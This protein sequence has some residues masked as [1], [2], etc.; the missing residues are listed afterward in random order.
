MSPTVFDVMTRG[1]PFPTPRPT[2]RQLPSDDGEPMDTPWHRLNMHLLIDQIN[3]RWRHRDDF[4][5]GGNMFV[6]FGD[7]E[8]FHKDFRGP[9]FFVVSGGVDRLKERD[10][11]VAWEE[12]DR[13]PDVI[14]E[15][16]SESTI[17]VDRVVKHAVYSKRMHCR[18][19]FIYDPS[20]DRLQGWQLGPGYEY[21]PLDQDDDDR[22]WSDV[23]GCSLGTWDGEYSE[24]AARWLRMYEL[25]GTLAPTRLEQT[26]ARLVTERDA[27]RAQ[28]GE[29]ARLRAELA[30]LRDTPPNTP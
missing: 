13:L 2:A 21:L 23:L 25:D 8:V 7:R 17:D 5:T 18:E 9:D 11:W 19:Y 26:E 1:K 30:A 4:Y 29:I 20:E 15:L 28:E 6:Y 10:S 27:L 22:L 14:V 3:S 16:A 12:D 24:H